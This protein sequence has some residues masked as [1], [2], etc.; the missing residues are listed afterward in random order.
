MGLDMSS[1]K[2]YIRANWSGV[3]AFAEWCHKSDLPNPFPTWNGGNAEFMD[4]NQCAEGWIKWRE[5]FAKK[6]PELVS[7][8]GPSHMIQ[9]TGMIKSDDEYGF[10]KRMAMAYYV[11]LDEALTD[12]TNICMG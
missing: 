2:N 11:M 5:A 3:R 9:M 1:A 12:K 4:Y 8:Y 7:E 10:E 6:Y